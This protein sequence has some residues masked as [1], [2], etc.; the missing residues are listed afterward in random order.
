M[1][2]LIVPLGIRKVHLRMTGHV[3]PSELVFC[4]A[5]SLAI[6]HPWALVQKSISAKSTLF[7]Y[8]N[9]DWNSDIE[10]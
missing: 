9:S 10:F 6:K 4:P 7:M 2:N 8:H 1:V 5:F 3:A